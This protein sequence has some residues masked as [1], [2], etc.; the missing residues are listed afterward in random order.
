[1]RMDARLVADGRGEV[2][3][4]EDLRGLEEVRQRLARRR[5]WVATLDGRV[6]GNAGLSVIDV[7]RCRHVASLYV[8]VDP[9][10]QRQGFGRALMLQV[11]EEARE[12][13]I[14]RL[15]LYVTADNQRARALYT[16]LGFEIESVRRDFLRRPDGTYADDL[17]MVRFLTER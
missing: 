4:P 2:R 7:A 8:A 13:G 9:H 1:M 15:E 5:I 6:V 14:H 10:A 17:C 12:R 16:S 11:L 3:G